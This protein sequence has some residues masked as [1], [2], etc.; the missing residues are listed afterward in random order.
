MI[1]VWKNLKYFEKGANSGRTKG[2][3]AKADGTAVFGRL[4][5]YLENLEGQDKEF[6][7]KSDIGV[8][9]KTWKMQFEILN[10][11]NQGEVEGLEDDV[12]DEENEDEEKEDVFKVEIRIY[13]N[14]E[15]DEEEE[16]EK[17]INI[18]IVKKEGSIVSFNK[19]YKKIMAE[20]LKMFVE[21][22][23]KQNWTP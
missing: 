18:Q 3:N 19:F 23:Q 20:A 22:E 16:A 8:S 15:E 4:F 11:D 2:F 1:D 14:N 13:A 7:L 10:L 12:T 21:P 17:D 9:E 5:R 6:E